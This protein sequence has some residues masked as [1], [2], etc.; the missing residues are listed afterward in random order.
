MGIPPSGNR[1]EMRS[2]DI[3]RVAAIIV[4]LSIGVVYGTDAV[5]ALVP[6]PA[7]ARVD[8][9]TPAAVIPHC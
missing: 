7:L 2:I 5:S 4:V 3:W 9:A 8:D 6:R 1:V